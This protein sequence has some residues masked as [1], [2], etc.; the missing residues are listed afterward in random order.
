RQ[1]Q[2]MTEHGMTFDTGFT[3]Q[4]SYDYSNAKVCFQGVE[5]AYSQMA[6][7]KYFKDKVKEIFNVDTW[8][9][10]MEAI[11]SGRA[12]YAVLPIENST[13]GSIAE[14]Y[15]L[16][17]EYEVAIVGEQILPVNHAL[18]GVKGA[19]ISDIMSVYS[20]PQAIMQCDSYLRTHHSDWNAVALRNTAMAAKKV[21]EDGDKTQ[22]AIGSSLNAE[23]Y[24]LDILE[25]CIQDN[26]GNATRFIVVSRVKKFPASA[27]KLSLA[28]DIP[29]VEGSLYRMLSHFIFNGLDLCH[30]ES[31]PIKGVNWNYRFFIDV[32]GNLNDDSVKNALSG[33]K[34]ESSDLIILGNYSQHTGV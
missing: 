4:E 16:L 10:A 13:A 22:A 29:N 2:I 15:D 27:D 1:Y 32:I 28:V 7:N 3:C 23:I 12:D 18:L 19:H 17:M 34:A 20:H 21:K 33:I 9:D 11:T 30:I 14:N 6:L 25:E 24:G 26:K 8:R 31:R 5:G